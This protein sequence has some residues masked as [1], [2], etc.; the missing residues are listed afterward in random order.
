MVRGSVAGR[1]ARR[2]GAVATL[3]LLPVLAAPAA[4][5][6]GSR[7]TAVADLERALEADPEQ[8]DL[9]S[10]LAACHST[11]AMLGLV[12]EPGAALARAAELAGRALRLDARRPRALLTLALVSLADGNR[13]NALGLARQAAE[14]GPRRP[15]TL[16][17]AGV[18]TMVC[19]DWG[20]GVA[21]HR[22][23]AAMNPSQAGRHHLYLALDS[24]LAG[25]DAQALLESNLV[26]HPMSA[27][28][29]LLRGLALA[30]LG[31]LEA[32]ETELGAAESA[33]PGFVTAQGFADPRYWDIAPVAR[34]MLTGR[35]GAL[36]ASL[37]DGL[38][39]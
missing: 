11:G 27:W 36:P 28:G 25:D 17:S 26:A 14:L 6:A 1:A 5:Y 16:F 12:P 38:R 33:E 15:S 21:M 18:V 9:L 23:L 22:E 8:P 7:D 20:Q 24:L 31:Y 32:A 4:S 29:S 37:V 2:A 13:Q 3:L 19:G 39:P 10:M 34:E 35:A 30:G